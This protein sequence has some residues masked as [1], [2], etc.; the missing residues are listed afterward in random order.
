MNLFFIEDTI[1]ES[2]FTEWLPKH[3][4][5]RRNLLIVMCIMFT[6]S[7][8]I[9]FISEFYK[10]PKNIEI[11]SVCFCIISA[12]TIIHIFISYSSNSCKNELN[13]VHT[14]RNEIIK[15]ISQETKKNGITDIILLNLNR[16]SEYYTINL[17]QA[18]NSYRYS[19]IGVC[20]GTLIFIYCIWSFI[21]NDNPNITVTI[22]GS[23]MGIITD[24][25]AASYFY[26][27]KKSIVQLNMYFKELIKIQDT[28]LAIELCNK[29]DTQSKEYNESINSI[30]ME[31]LKRSS[32][33]TKE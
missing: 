20:I 8:S 15:R 6:L 11:I 5:I 17:T 3:P 30:I 10:V 22:I 1:F 14:E 28:M 31:L 23:I 12:Y 32:Q 27:Y 18:K 7:I 24:F 26:L 16:L 19:I 9:G 2:I 33:N 21:G 29:I 4:K 13:N 25:I